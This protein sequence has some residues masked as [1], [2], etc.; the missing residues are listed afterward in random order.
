M[1]L[2]TLLGWLPAAGIAGTA[3]AVGFGVGRM[4]SPDSSGKASAEPNPSVVQTNTVP[5][6]LSQGN[7]STTVIQGHESTGEDL[8]KALGVTN[9]KT[10]NRKLENA[11][12]EASLDDVKTALEWAKNLPDGPAKRAAM[13]KV[14]ARWGEL[15]GSAATT[16]AS[17]VLAQTGNP[18]LL[19]EA[20]KGWGETDPKA[21]IQYAQ[22]I[23]GNN[24]VKGDVIRTVLQDWAN[25]NPQEAAAYVQS[26]NV[27]IGGGGRG[28]FGWGGGGGPGGF[29]GPAGALQVVADSWSQQD[30]AAAAAWAGTLQDQ[31]EQMFTMGQ[32]IR[33]W[34]GND[35][36][37]AA[38]FVNSQPAGQARD[39]MVVSMA[40]EVAQQDPSSAL[41]WAASVSDQR[42]QERAAMGVVFQ[43]A[44]QDQA[45]AQ[46]LIQNSGLQDSVKQ[47]LQ[48][49]V[50]N[51]PG[52]GQGQRGQQGGN[53]GGR[54]Q[55]GGGQQ[56]AP[57]INQG[58]GAP[59]ANGNPSQVPQG[60]TP[61]A[62][63]V[64]SVI[65]N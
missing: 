28:G 40:R 26:T 41:K 43:A 16:Y 10:R 61:S 23:N 45:A 44:G 47:Q 56:P 3:M 60:G 32:V 36:N 25:Q 49:M 59:Q 13:S 4:T 19:R 24:G 8:N 63:P 33:N 53:N 22:A 37:A 11:L 14:M 64:T 39:A 18:N 57:Q 15:E 54:Q 12:A 46:Q 5:V 42:M 38:A 29:G 7:Q 52:R 65:V 2:Q 31:R 6:S 30:P 55:Q 51:G 27:T 1:N 35:I 62:K 9:P 21:S 48:N 34:A 20:L 50:A 17:Q 58:G